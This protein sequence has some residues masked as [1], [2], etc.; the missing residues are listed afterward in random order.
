[1]PKP[2][3]KTTEVNLKEIKLALS[4]DLVNQPPHKEILSTVYRLVERFRGVLGKLT[5]VKEENRNKFGRHIRTQ[6]AIHYE[7]ARIDIDLLTNPLTQSQT[8]YGFDIK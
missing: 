2:K 6:Y 7:N 1:M 4:I 3:Q 5:D 8:V